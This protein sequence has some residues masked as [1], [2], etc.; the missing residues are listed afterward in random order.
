MPNITATQARR[1]FGKLLDDVRDDPVFVSRNGELSAVVLSWEAFKRV[2][3]RTAVDTP[4]PDIDALL[5]TAIERHA[6]V[7]KALAKLD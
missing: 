1:Q 2:I 6:E 4:R 7:F 5:R 3:D